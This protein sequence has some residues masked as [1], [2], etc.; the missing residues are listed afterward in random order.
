MDTLAERE[1][2]AEIYFLEPGPGRD[3]MTE[4]IIGHLLPG[5]PEAQMWVIEQQN[6]FRRWLVTE[7]RLA[8]GGPG[9]RPLPLTATP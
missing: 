8:A 3:E 6:L 2:F 9:G 7:V 1:V 5:Y 4:G